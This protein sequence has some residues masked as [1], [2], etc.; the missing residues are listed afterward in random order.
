MGNGEF[1]KFEV[2][3]HSDGVMECARNRYPSR[4]LMINMQWALVH[5]VRSRHVHIL[6][7]RPLD[8]AQTT[9]D[10]PRLVCIVISSWCD[11]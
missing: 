9:D 6:G 1:V 8:L 2:W 4:V 3:K 11:V 7:Y 5:L 10:M